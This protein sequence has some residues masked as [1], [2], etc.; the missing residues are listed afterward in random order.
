MPDGTPRKLMDVSKLKNL[1]WES[2][3]SLKSGLAQTYNW[4][5][6]NI[7]EVRSK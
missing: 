5:K 1:G 7:E 3:I 2:S 4:F 6:N